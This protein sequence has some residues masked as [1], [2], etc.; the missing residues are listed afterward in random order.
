MNPVIQ[1]KQFEKKLIRRGMLKTIN[2]DVIKPPTR[3]YKTLGEEILWCL[4]KSDAKLTTSD[5]ARYFGSDIKIIQKVMRKL[6]NSTTKLVKL[7]KRKNKI[8][9][10]AKFQKD[11]DIPTAYK[12]IRMGATK[13]IK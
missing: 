9:Y 3:L 12:L 10:T 6:T 11:L 1:K 7:N 2:G 5:F 4:N 13:K 8:Y